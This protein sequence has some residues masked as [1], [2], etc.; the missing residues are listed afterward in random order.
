MAVKTFTTGEVLTAADTNTYLNN[1]GLVYV[2]GVT[3][4]GSG[5]YTISNCFSATY[6]NYRVI[7]SGISASGAID[8]NIRMGTTS[9]GYYG[10]RYYDAYTGAATGTIRFNNAAQFFC[11]GATSGND[12][13]ASGFDITNPQVAKRTSWFGN[14]YGNA[15]AGWFGGTVA[16]STQ[17]TDL[18]L[19]PSAGTFSATVRIYGYR[20]A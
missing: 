16:N 8:L 2:T 19:L 14:Y 18:Q 5:G 4:S 11:G 6:E 15:F 17:Y 7:I 10:S 13:G 9:T 12:E 20:Q 3:I 1:G